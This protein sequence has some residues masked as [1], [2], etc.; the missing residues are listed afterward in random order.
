MIRVHVICEGQTE[1]TFVREVLAPYFQPNGVYLTPTKIGRPGHK[2]GYFTFDRLF[3]DLQARLLGDTESYSTTFFDFYGLPNDFP[4]KNQ[5]SKQMT[6]DQK[7]ECVLTHLKSLLENKLGSGPMSRFIPY[8][9]M[10]EF[11]GLLF[12]ETDTLATAVGQKKISANLQK[13]RESFPT[14]E[15]INDS[16]ID[17]PSKRILRL[18]SGYEKTFHGN[19]AAIDIGIDTIRRECR[20]FSQWVSKLES[21]AQRHQS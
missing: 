3:D 20:L 11:E 16:P 10:H 12:S 19:I 21:L 2:G 17:A 5:T 14:P 1:E 8:I 13:I 18:Y 4:G 9:Q 6:I 15:H 7:S